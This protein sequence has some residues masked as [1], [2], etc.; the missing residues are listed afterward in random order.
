MTERPRFKYTL[1]VHVDGQQYLIW[2]GES[3]KM[4]ELEVLDLLDN[5]ATVSMKAQRLTPEPKPGGL[6]KLMNRH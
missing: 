1:F 6:L 2:D 3:R 5:G 4:M